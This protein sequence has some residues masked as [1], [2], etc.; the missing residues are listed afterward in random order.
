MLSYSLYFSVCCELF[1]YSIKQKRFLKTL[2][3]QYIIYFKNRRYINFKQ[4]QINYKL[5]DNKQ[6]GGNQS[7]WFFSRVP[8]CTAFTVFFV[9]SVLNNFFN[10]L[11]DDL[12][13]NKLAKQYKTAS[14]CISC[15]G[16][17]AVDLDNSSCARMDDIGTTSPDKSTWWY[18]DLGDI[19]SLYNIRIQ[20]EDYED[21]SKYSHK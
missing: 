20:F 3:N 18:V 15:V 2:V 19:Y 4:N 12:S 1:K 17:K 11:T 21:F 10:F 9:S 14:T 13:A 6:V 16:T 8:V 5:L 7:V